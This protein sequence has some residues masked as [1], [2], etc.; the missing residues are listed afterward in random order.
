MKKFTISLK[1]CSFTLL[2]AVFLSFSSYGPTEEEAV[3]VQQKLYNH[4]N[5]EVS[6]KSIKKYELHVTNTGFCRYKCFLNS[7]K[8]EYFSFNLLK[9]KEIDYAG[10]TQT[11]TLILRTKGDD[12]IVQTYNDSKG[13]DVDSMSTF[14]V[15]PLKNIE[16][17]ELND[18]AEKFQRMSEKLH[19]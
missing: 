3:Y 19:Q 9:Y 17:E 11:G 6:G 16:P 2:C 18:L 7:G 12:V 1:I 14:M 13:E 4:Y 8:I 5:A 10:T 15:I